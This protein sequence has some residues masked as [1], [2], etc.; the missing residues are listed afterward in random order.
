[1]ADTVRKE[2][3]Y[4]KSAAVVLDL[5]FRQPVLFKGLIWLEPGN[6]YRKI[7]M[8][9]KNH[10]VMWLVKILAKEGV[11]MSTVWKGSPAAY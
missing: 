2:V 5:S 4:G 11:V 8:S 1:M 6:M 9:Q 7:R 10:V 3:K